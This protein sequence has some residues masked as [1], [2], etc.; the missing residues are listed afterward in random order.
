MSKLSRDLHIDFE[1]RSVSTVKQYFL[2]SDMTR[3]LNEPIAIIGSACRFAQGTNSPSEL[4]DLLQKPRDILQEIPPSRFSVNG[5]YHENGS[6]HGRTNVKHAYLLDGSPFVFD[7]EFFGIKPIEAKAT[8]PQQRCLL[9]VAYEALE[10]AGL[11]LHQVKGSDTGVYVGAM[12][13]D[14]SALA[15]RDLSDVP[16]Y[17]ATGTAAS[18]LSNRLSYFFDWHGPSIT[19]DTACSS[20]LVAVHLAIQAL[21]SGECSTALACGSNLILS[22]DNFIIESKLKM[23]SPDGRSRMW[24]QAANGYARGEGIG[25]LVLKP[26][27][28]A[29]RDNDPIESVI[30]ET[31]VNQDGASNSAGITV[32]SASAQE[33]L[34][35][36]TYLKAGLN[37][38]MTQ[39]QPQFFEAHGTGTTVGDPIEAQAIYN[40][41]I[42]RHD[43]SASP[44]PPLYVGSIK[45]ILGHTEGTAGLAALMKA[46]L[47]LKNR[48]IPP[49]MLLNQLS[50]RVGPYYHGLE[51]PVI[52]KPWP[53]TASANG[54]R[55]ASVNS[56]GFGGANAHAILES[57]DELMKAHEEG[58]NFAPFVFSAFSEQSLRDCLAGYA[59]YLDN[60]AATIN[61]QD[62]SWTLHKRRTI[63]PYRTS[64]PLSSCSELRDHIGTRLSYTSIATKALPASTR[65]RILGIFT[66]QG[67]QYPRMGAE[68]VEKSELARSII[69][70]LETVLSQLPD[71]P[72]WSL[73]TELL[74]GASSSR[75]YEAAV[76]Q[77]LCTAVQILLVDLVR[78]AGIEFDTVIG[79]SSGEIAAAY[80][81]GYITSSDAIQIAYYRGLHSQRTLSPNGQQIK[82]AMLAVG[83]SIEDLDEICRDPVFSGRVAIAACNSPSSFTV[84]GDED[85][86]DEMQI[87]LEDEGK[88]NRRLRVDKAYHSD[89]MK[90][91]FQPYIDSLSSCGLQKG[92]PTPTCAWISSV[93]GCAMDP[94]STISAQYWAENMTQK[95][96]FSQAIEDAFRCDETS[97][98]LVLELGAHPALREPT[99]QTIRSTSSHE[100]PYTGF[101]SRG[102]NAIEASSAGLGFAWT[103][104]ES[105]RVDLDTYDRSLSGRIDGFQVVKDLPTYKWNHTKSYWQESRIS[106]RLRDRQDPAHPLLGDSTVDSASHCMS[107]RNVL[108]VQELEWMAGHRV[109]GQVVFP[110][111]GYIVT[112]LEV[113]R[114][115][116]RRKD[117][118]IRLID[119]THFKVHQALVFDTDD[120]RI[121]TFTQVT[122]I[123]FDE[124]TGR[125]HGNFTFSAAH[126]SR[127]NDLTLSASGCLDI[128]VGQAS[129]A[130][131][132]SR[133]AP[134]PH[135]IDVETD[136]FYQALAELGY[137]F[138]G[139]FK[140]LTE[141]KRR[142]QRSSCVVEM[143]SYEGLLIHPANLDAVLQA[144]IL[145]YSYPYDQQLRTP[146]LPTEIRR[147]RVNP[148]I[149]LDDQRNT[150]K[151]AEFI[152]ESRIH[153]KT[154]DCSGI[155]GDVNL[156]SSTTLDGAVQVQ[157]ATFLPI[158]HLGEIDD[159]KLFSKVH[160]IDTALD[161]S[162]ISAGIPLTDEHRRLLNVLERIATF[163]M[164][165]FDK[166]I[167][168][169]DPIRSQFPLNYYLN[170]CHHLST[171]FESGK[172]EW[173]RP[174]WLDDTS[175]VIQ[176]AS[177]EFADVVDVEIM[178]L[179]GSQMPRVFRGE[180]T[181]L[182][183]FRNDGSVGILDRYYAEGFGLQESAQWISGAVKQIT[184][185]Y[186]HMNIME[187]GK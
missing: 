91:C 83:T 3:N 126:T 136:R 178:H 97:Y 119:I 110:A 67:A 52:A 121:E 29:L 124:L 116:A 163:Y 148:K 177:G 10:S 20:S 88:F 17:T 35:R 43:A 104:L 70:K 12:C 184:E 155:C 6:H 132:P 172:G 182:E 74:A 160:W 93:Y 128:F 26:L 129:S 164:R 117:K 143:Q 123:A 85:A 145:A 166:S 78:L 180:T 137:E 32:P 60:K 186:P 76:S 170:Y 165:K 24:D 159:R 102:T 130:L 171:L 37:L 152:V 44:D 103:Q 151:R 174:E 149:L 28:A 158:G 142:H 31:A 68:L 15:I 69:A 51:V 41:F 8:D 79:H 46:S 176:A 21:R 92:T 5:H 23:L 98:D 108:S 135:M 58:P 30:R 39:D 146:H 156:Y 77:P 134:L 153:E 59:Q 87:L 80:A 49:N 173:G 4:W 57:C 36:A 13:Y 139:H 94:G 122:G 9:E 147:I 168:M 25:A 127:P 96:L 34:I 16:V 47:A 154:A 162:A 42:T 138:S 33:A 65:G 179:V 99:L 2:R 27:S 112:A 14:Y 144:C 62:L 181:M 169:D 54:I 107:W 1:T 55:R 141:L 120:T 133:N 125:L 113:A 56:F 105:G 111:A 81:S 63:F 118:T 157:G 95:V 11:P 66:G 48:V 86:I 109:Q 100:I 50:D 115:L 40:T 64:F 18:L 114:L 71:G 150:T 75:V 19:I 73:M 175:E 131:L 161:E 90:P 53:Q 183:E 61:S 187:I 22:P 38:S 84:S 140:A 185:R 82:G 89:H 45:T 101:L 167:P 7:A 106:R 72:E